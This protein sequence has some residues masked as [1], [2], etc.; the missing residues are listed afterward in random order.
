MS[1]I[2]AARP[3]RCAGTGCLLRHTGR[4]L[5]LPSGRSVPLSFRSCVPVNDPADLAVQCILICG[6]IPEAVSSQ[7][8]HVLKVIT[9][10]FH[11][12][13]QSVG[14][15][16][17][18]APAVVAVGGS[19]SAVAFSVI[20]VRRDLFEQPVV[21]IVEITG[22]GSSRVRPVRDPVLQVILIR[23]FQVFF[24]RFFLR[25]GPVYRY[26]QGIPGCIVSVTGPPVDAVLP[27]QNPLFRQAV[28]CVKVSA[29]FKS[30][31]H[32]DPVLIPVFI[33]AVAGD[34]QFLLILLSEEILDLIFSNI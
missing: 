7:G 32:P 26:A 1:G 24:L 14:D 15:A 2:S 22:D 17:E 12:L 20:T 13:V 31:G 28:V 25:A 21:L 27:V 3:G 23:G 6:L 34:G 11:H 30:S 33:V 10:L 16:D 8:R 18:V 5:Y 19:C 9:S 29:D 4:F